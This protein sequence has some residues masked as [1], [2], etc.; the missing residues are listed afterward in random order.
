MTYTPR[1]F[2]LVLSLQPL[3]IS[4][5][6]SQ[7]LMARLDG[8][9]LLFA[10]EFLH[11]ELGWLQF[12]MLP[13]VDT[14]GTILL[15]GRVTIQ[16]NPRLAL[17]RAHFVFES[18]FDEEFSSQLFTAQERRADGIHRSVCRFDRSNSIIHVHQWR[19]IGGRIADEQT[20]THPLLPDL[21]DGIAFFYFL[22]AAVAAPAAGGADLAAKT[23]QVL[24]G[25]RPD[26]VFIRRGPS[27]K[28]STGK[29]PELRLLTPESDVTPITCRLAFTGIAGLRREILSFFTT[30]GLALPLSTELQVFFGKVHLRLVEQHRR[31]A[32]LTAQ[33]NGAS[34][35]LLEVAKELSK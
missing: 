35:G 31:L 5:T 7:S 1:L 6:F 12:E 19:E 8:E 20:S 28:L 25:E 27:T 16:A 26:S 3:A 30:D 32:E 9:R 2:V 13:P 22:R 10:A 21:R 29:L 33:N 17:M 18:Y 34:A 14:L 11:M 24:S 23:F 15:H 4:S